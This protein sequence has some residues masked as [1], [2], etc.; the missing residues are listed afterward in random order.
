MQFEQMNWQMVEEYLKHDDRIM[1]VLGS[2][3]Q[4]SGLSLLTDSL[5]PLKLAER[6][7][8]QSGVLV[9]PPLHYGVSPYFLDFPGT[10]SLRLSTYLQ[11]IDDLASCLHA[12]GFKRMLFLNGHGGNAPARTQLTELVN[13]F[14]EL[15]LRWYQWWTSETVANFS[16]S[17]G[18]PNAHANWE[19]N[20]SFTR[21]G[22]A[23]S[24]T[25][26]LINSDER[27]LGKQSTRALVGDGSY[28]GPWQV[29][30]KLMDELF[31]LCL[32]EVLKLL[33]FEVE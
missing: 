16:K 22:K 26:A 18:L 2:T 28:G 27:I 14:P 10:L 5:I 24:G 1:I 11:V 23:S 20:F 25:K 13:A 31:A 30:D 19:E 12:Q 8:E 33:E 9:A 15:D 7:S 4:H 32:A 21:L 29:D 3:E 6:A 17:R